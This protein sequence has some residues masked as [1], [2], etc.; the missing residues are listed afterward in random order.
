MRVFIQNLRN[1]L[2]IFLIF[3]FISASSSVHEIIPS[4]AFTAVQ[5]SA[6]PT[7]DWITNGG[8][9]S[10]QRFSPLTE[11]TPDNISSLKAVWRTSLVGSGTGFWHSNQTQLLVYEGTLYASTGEN[12]VFAI[13]VENGNIIWKYQPHLDQN[14]LVLCCGWVTRG[15]GMGDGRIY[16]GQLDAKLV[17]L[18]QRTGEIIWTVQAELPEQGYSIT[19]APLYYNG[20]VITGFAGGEYGI[21]GRVKA[22]DARDGTLLW[23]FYT[24]PGP[25]ETGHNTWP[26]DNYAWQTGGAPVW[27]TPAVDP[28]LGLLYFSTGNPAPDQN[29]SQRAGDNLFSVSIVA[30]D[31]NAGTYRWHFQQVRHDIWDYDSPNPIILFDAEYNG[32]TRKGLT[33]TSKSGYLYILDRVTGEPLV[34]VD[35]IQVPQLAS[36]LTAATQPIPRG[37]KIIT[38]S[39]DEVP[40]GWTLT[41]DGMTFTPFGTT[42]NLYTP[43][44]G[45]SWPP[46]SYDP[47]SNLV[48]VCANES[49]GGARMVGLSDTGPQPPETWM[50]GEWTIPAATRR[51]IFA[52]MD[53]K[54]HLLAWRQVW[55]DS[56]HSGSVVTAGGLVFVGHSD[57]RLTALDKINGSLLWEFQTDGGV[58]TT[59]SIFEYKGRQHVAV[60]AGGIAFRSKRNDGIWLFSLD[61]RYES[62]AS[63]NSL[64]PD[65]IEKRTILMLLNRLLDD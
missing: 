44:S 62:L 33:G 7:S 64:P 42:P 28:E 18:D 32:E 24:I 40:N 50:G 19:S 54:T 35:Y 17:A 10:N 63:I 46:S 2:L 53:L 55:E 37:D 31:I 4:P 43:L 13:D 60:H 56:C 25:G 12:E 11:I 21:R 6:A 15:V 8:N 3:T 39:I 27:Q 34:P 47:E 59:V 36:Q 51:G 9:L 20:M 41:N 29:G 23:T 22:F 16:V 1:F 52:A 57:G 49:I 61:G 14:N 38:H 45:I 26:Q 30:I 58:N 65:E 48:Y 5:L